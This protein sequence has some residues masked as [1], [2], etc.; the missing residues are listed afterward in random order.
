M[1]KKKNKENNLEEKEIL[2]H[3]RLFILSDF[4]SVKYCCDLLQKFINNG[5]AI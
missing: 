4:V 1:A 2:K 3:C 5:R